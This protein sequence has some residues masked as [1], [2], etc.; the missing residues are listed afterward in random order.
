[1]P[2]TSEL[3]VVL[4]SR[5]FDLQQV[6]KEQPSAG[7]EIMKR[8]IAI[9]AAE[10]LPDHWLGYDAVDVL[11]MSIDDGPLWREL[12]ADSER[13]AAIEEWVE[14]GGRLVLMCGGEQAEAAFGGGSG[15]ATLLPGKFADVVR[16]LPDT[17]RLEQYANSEAS[18][19]AGG[20]R[21]TISVPRLTDVEGNIEVYVGQRPRDLPL[22]V[23]S[24]RELGEIAFVGLDFAKPPLAN[25]PG[26]TAFLQAVL[27]PYVAS[28][29][30]RSDS[31]TLVTR[32][33]NDLSGALRQSL[34]RSFAGLS[35]VTFSGVTLLALAY[36]LVLGPI[37]YF[38]IH[39]WLGR[40][41]MAWVT[42]PLFVLLFTGAAL[43]L[44]DWRRGDGGVR[45]N[46]REVIDVD[47]LS[48]RT[49]GS[50]WATLYAPRAA[51]LNLKFESATISN[52]VAATSQ[53]SAWGLPGVGIGGMQSGGLDLGIV[54]N[55]Y[56]YVDDLSGLEGVPVLTSSTKSFNAGW[57]TIVTPP[58]AATL[59]DV[60]GLVE[61][62][63]ENHTGERLLNV[64]LFYNGWGYQLGNVDDGEQVTVN[65]ELS[66]LRV[67]TIVT[68]SAIGRAAAR[69]DE[70]FVFRPEDVGAD[71]L[72]NLI[73]FYEAAGGQ[74]FVQ[75]P[76]RY[77]ADVDLSRLLDLGRAVVVANVEG[78]GSRLLDTDSG[79]EL[80][81]A[82]SAEVIYR[83]VLPVR[84]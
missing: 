41:I 62:T 67:K 60:D 55:E 63:I 19:G 71:G 21:A 17:G 43:A 16:R 29:G 40:P 32:G 4:S 61:G 5:P 13:L 6:Y 84:N 49:R 64:L 1:M 78:G 31:Q 8:S 20:V 45:V 33:Y 12:A 14:L 82:D 25:W 75:L 3:I 73:M 68:R 66:P 30:D 10:E 9:S 70:S 35:P 57:Q 44:T 22:V 24:P 28:D 46:R 79:D 59:T 36:L 27:R 38:V 42:F 39:R 37:D 53:L 81:K 34:G 47:V 51:R 58:L 77:Q 48:G 54:R 52:E 76:N 18:I 83:F 65:D 26:R 11:V 50:Y 56:R 2:A 72:L 23:R 15:L 69:E 74:A 7:S 80:G